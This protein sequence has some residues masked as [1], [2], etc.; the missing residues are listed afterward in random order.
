MGKGNSGKSEG[1]D[2]KCLRLLQLGPKRAWKDPVA[3]LLHWPPSIAVPGHWVS[4]VS[5]G[6]RVRHCFLLTVLLALASPLTPK[7][8]EVGHR[9]GSSS[10]KI[11]KKKK[12]I[13]THFE[14]SG[15]LCS[16]C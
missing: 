14:Y 6:S 13:L 3:S 2:R 8:L 4:A 1:E 5:W 7:V 12:S 10:M 9:A 11:K 15:V 16:V